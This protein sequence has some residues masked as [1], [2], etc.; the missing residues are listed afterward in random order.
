MIAKAKAIS[1]GHAHLEYIKGESPN[2]KHRDRIFHVCE[3]LLPK[4]A[5][6]LAV[7][8]AVCD[9]TSGR[10]R[11]KNSLVRIVVSPSPEHTRDFGIADWQKL[12]LDFA[13][14]FDS[15]ELTDAKGRQYAPRTNILGSIHTVELHMESESGVPH[16]HAAVCRVD[17]EGRTN[18]DHDIHL[19]AQRAAE[20]VA[21]KRGWKTAGEVRESAEA[22]ARKD[23]M[24]TL[25]SMKE[26]SLHAYLSA[27][28]SK[29]Y[30]ITVTRD[31]KG[32]PRGYTLRQGKTPIK[33]SA[34]DRK[35]TLK[36]LPQ[37][38]AQL[39]KQAQPAA[40]AA[41]Q[42]PQ[43]KPQAPTPARTPA[44]T[45]TRAPRW[46]AYSTP[47]P[48]CERHAFSELF[49]GQDVYVPKEAMAEF[50]KEFDPRF[51]ANAAELKDF[52]VAM[53]VM[54][55]GDAEAAMTGA[56]GGGSDNDR[57][58]GRKED[59]DDRQWAIRCARKAASAIAPRPAYR[60]SR[61]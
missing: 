40:Q 38:W 50:D 32:V 36:R 17:S 4:N 7:W 35:L 6:A 60:R 37:T 61:R 41:A 33:A 48:G 25:I 28:A 5:C 24:E 29:G 12:W 45:A 34:I 13:R 43:R 54:L 16:L 51:V 10:S 14:E 30:D 44:P 56:G 19:R 1:H 49:A 3:N 23:C 15:I 47:R 52:A 31:S 55:I 53:F 20:A 57:D 9:A 58:W 59:E 46:K 8:D 18:S 42:P 39:R 21:R 26:W 2:K 22:Q 11:M 27:L